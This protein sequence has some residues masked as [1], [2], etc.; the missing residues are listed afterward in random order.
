MRDENG[1]IRAFTTQ[2]VWELSNGKPMKL[3]VMSGRYDAERQIHVPDARYFVHIRRGIRYVSDKGTLKEWRAPADEAPC[4][5]CLIKNRYNC[6][7]QTL[8][9]VDDRIFLLEVTLP[10]GVEDVVE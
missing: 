8:K 1:N 9:K 7:K 4:E 6:D 10:V 5:Y 3:A 2:D